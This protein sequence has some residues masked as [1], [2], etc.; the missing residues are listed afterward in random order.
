MAYA[1]LGT[2]EA[3]SGPLA[4]LLLIIVAVVL[5]VSVALFGQR[6]SDQADDQDIPDIGFVTESPNV[7]VAQAEQ[8]LDWGAHFRF[9]GSCTPLLNGAGP[10]S[11]PVIAGDVLNCEA[12]ETLTIRSSPAYG[13]SL[14]YEASF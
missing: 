11:G 9:D 13:N 14:L 5:A 8:S 4:I 1:R 6:L 12:G 7:R 10:P 2:D 3:V